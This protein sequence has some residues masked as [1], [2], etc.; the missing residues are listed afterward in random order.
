MTPTASSQSG[1]A[2]TVAAHPFRSA[3]EFVYLPVRSVDLHEAIGRLGPIYRRYTATDAYPVGTSNA[4]DSVAA[5]DI[6]MDS[7]P[8][9]DGDA[10]DLTGSPADSA[11]GS[12]LTRQGRDGVVWPPSGYRALAD[13]KAERTRERIL[14]IG[15]ALCEADGRLRMTELAEVSG[16]SATAI[17]QALGKLSEYISRHMDTF[18]NKWRWPFGWEVGRKVDPEHPREFHYYMTPAQ[19][20]AWREAYA[21]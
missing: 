17:P 13:W 14:A 8:S 15:E 21:S 19:R 10:N 1:F 2:S 9:G 18:D 7:T 4:A 11:S 12:W 3:A 20:A 5:A 6:T 16:V